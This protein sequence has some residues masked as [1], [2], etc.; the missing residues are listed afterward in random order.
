MGDFVNMKEAAR[1]LGCSV[2]S[3]RKAIA[4]GTLKAIKISD[5]V[6][7]IPREALEGMKNGTRP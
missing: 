7:R 6:I 1:I 5:R 4:M 3:V 2:P